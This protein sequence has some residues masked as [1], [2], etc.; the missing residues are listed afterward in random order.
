M[1]NFYLTAS[2]H[3]NILWTIVDGKVIADR[4]GAHRVGKSAL[5]LSIVSAL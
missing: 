3:D 5:V 4:I 1:T 2:L